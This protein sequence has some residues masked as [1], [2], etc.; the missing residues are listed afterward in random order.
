VFRVVH[1]GGH[2]RQHG[3]AVFGHNWDDMPWKWAWNNQSKDWMQTMGDNQHSQKT[4][5]V[6]GIG[7]TRHV[8][9][10]TCAGGAFS[11]P[12]DYLFRTQEAFQFQGGLWGLFRVT[13]GAGTCT[14]DAVR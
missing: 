6:N 10:R 12:G 8:N 14:V 13:P 9:L 1:P 5:S 2:P 11:Q 4:G 7:P 3:F